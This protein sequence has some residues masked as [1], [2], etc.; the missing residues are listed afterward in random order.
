MVVRSLR[1]RPS[2]SLGVR[3][4]AQCGNRFSHA[5]GSAGMHAVGLRRHEHN[6][7]EHELNDTSTVCVT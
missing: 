1:P 4:V 5:Q 6:Q 3:G 2:R 7:D